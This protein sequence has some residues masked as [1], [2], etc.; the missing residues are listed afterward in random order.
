MRWR[1]RQLTRSQLEERRLA[2]GRLLHAG[3]LSHA[4]IARQMGVSRTAVSRW[5]HQRRQGQGDLSRLHKRRVPGRPP[6]LTPAQWQR[7]RRVL[8]RGAR[9]AGFDTDRWTLG[10]RR[11]VM[12]VEFGVEYHPHDLPHRLKTLGW[13]PQHPAVYARQRDDAVVQ[14]WLTP[15]WA[16]IHKRLGAEARNWS[17]S[18]EP[19][20][21]VAPGRARPGL[22]GGQRPSCGVSADAVS[23]PRRSASRYP[24]SLPRATLR[25]PSVPRTFFGPCDTSR[26]PSPGR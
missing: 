5:A 20:S 12:L 7:R 18:A 16:R 9:P 1:P 8:G 21:R 15:D 26:G 25:L 3:Q 14:A 2:A 13:R 11:A 23:D 10:R 24:A 6:R 4:A 22:R 19:G 17:A